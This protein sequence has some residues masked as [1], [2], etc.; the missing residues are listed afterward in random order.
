M[1]RLN[2]GSNAFFSVC[3][4]IILFSFPAAAQRV[5]ENLSGFDHISYSSPQL[6]T[7]ETNR[8]V[9]NLENLLPEQEAASRFIKAKGDGWSVWFDLRRGRPSLIDGGAIP[10]IPGHAN[11]LR[12]EDFAPGCKDNSSLPPEKVEELA[13]GFIR[14]WKDLLK[15]DQEELILDPLG[16]GPVGDSYYL[17]RFQWAPSGIPVEGASVYFRINGGNLLQVATREIGDLKLDITPHLSQETA[18]QILSG[19][20][21]GLAE[22][23][24]ILERGRLVIVPVTPR[25]EDSNLF[26]GRFGGMMDYRLCYKLVFEREG[27]IGRWESLVDAHSGELLSFRDS[28]RYGTVRGTIY[29][30][31]DKENILSLP[32][33]FVKTDIPAPNNF[34]DFAGRFEGDQATLNMENARF[35]KMVDGC[36]NSSLTTTTG[37]ADYGQ[38][39]GEDCGVPSPNPAGGGNTWSIKTLYYHLT[40][41]NRKAAGFLPANSWLSQGQITVNV[42]KS[43]FCN[44]SAGATTINFYKSA[45]GCMNYGELPG[46]GLHEWGHSLDVNDGSGGWTSPCE[47]I[48]DWNAT[49][50][51]RDSCAGKGAGEGGNC[52][53]YGDAC[54]SCDGIRDLDYMKHSSQTP[55]TAQN[56]GTLWD[57]A[58][59]K[60]NGPCGW[61]DHCESGIASQALWDFVNRDLPSYCGISGRD[62]WQLAEMLFYRALPTL[63][64][65]YSCTVGA[66]TVTDGC[67]G[68]SLYTVMRFFDDS[69]DGTANGTPHAK[70]IY[71]AL[72][73]HNIA[74]GAEQDA[75]NQNQSGC[76]SMSTP[77]LTVAS[78]A[79]DQVYLEWTSAGP[80]ATWYGIFRNDLGPDFGFTK[81]G[82]VS[83]PATNFYDNFAANGVW[84]NYVVQAAAGSESCAGP[85]SNIVSANPSYWP[86]LGAVMLDSSKFNCDGQ[87]NITVTDATPGTPVTVQAWST[88]DPNPITIALAPDPTF[89]YRYVGSI[90]TSV[91]A[92]SGKVRV[93]HGDTL[94][95]KYIDP[96]DG[97]GNYNVGIFTHAAIDCQGPQISN[98]RAVNV[99]GT[100]MN[101]V[102]DTDE[103]STTSVQ[104]FPPPSSTSDGGFDT[105]HS[106]S[107]SGLQPCTTY[108]FEMSSAD[109]LGNISTDNNGG[110]Y[111]AFT[112]IPEL[113]PVYVRAPAQTIPDNDFDGV[114]SASSV[115]DGRVVQDLNVSVTIDHPRTSDLRLYVENPNGQ[116]VA[117]VEN[118]PTSGADF[119]GTTFDDD[120]DQTLGGSFG[121]YPG[122]YRPTGDL[123]DYDG[124]QMNGNWKLVV[125]DTVPGETGT[126]VEWELLPTYATYNCGAELDLHD[127]YIFS[128]HCTGS[129]GGEDG[130]I[131]AG[132]EVTLKAYLYNNGS[133]ETSQV[134][135]FLTS[136]SPFVTIVDGSSSFSDILPGGTGG[137]ADSFKILVSPDTQCGQPLELNL[138]I[139]CYEEP[140]GWD[141][142]VALI[143]GDPDP[144]G[145][146]VNA[147]QEDFE[148]IVTG[149]P[150]GWKKT[151]AS[152]SWLVGRETCCG[153]SDYSLSILTGGKQADAWMFTS[154]MELTPGTLYTLQFSCN[155]DNIDSG[156][157]Q[158][159][160]LYLGSGQDASLMNMLL[161]RETDLVISTGCITYTVEFTVPEQAEYYLGIYC[162]TPPGSWLLVIDDI[163]ISYQSVASC[164]MNPC[165]PCEDPGAPVITSITDPYPCEAGSLRVWF[166]EGSGAT[167]HDLYMDGTLVMYGIPSSPA[168]IAPGDDDPH[169]FVIRAINGECHTDSA[170]VTG[171]D[172]DGPA[173]G[174]P[175]P[176]AADADE[177][178]PTGIEVSWPAV[179]GATS[180]DLK[181][182]GTTIVDDAA[183][184]YIYSPGNSSS[185]AFSVRAKNG[186]CAGSWSSTVSS[187]DLVLKPGTPAVPAV[188][189][190]DYCA[191]TGV[192]VSWI[193]VP[194]ATD[195]DLMIDGT[196]VINSV[197]SPHVYLPGNTNTHNY[198]VRAIRSS[199]KGDFSPASAGID[200]ITL[201][202]PAP[203]SV[204]DIDPCAQSG[205]SV[206]WSPVPGATTYDL[207]VDGSD[208]Y[209]S[210]TSPYAFDPKDTAVH[211]YSI[212]P[213]SPSCDGD[214][215]DNTEQADLNNGVS[216]PSSFGG[217]DDD[218]CN[219][220]G[221]RL[222]WSAASGATGYDLMVDSNTITGVSSPYVHVP[223][224]TDTHA[225]RVRAKN[226]SCV[227]DWTASL[228][229]KDSA[230]GPPV[231]D[232]APGASDL[233]A[234][235]LTGIRVY[236]DPLP[237]ATYHDIRVDGTTI[238]PDA[239]TEKIIEPGDSLP[240][241]FEYRGRTAVCTG[242]WSPS[243][244][245][246]DING[247]PGAPVVTSVDDINPSFP[248]GVRVNF[249][250]GSGAERHDLYMDGAQ[251]VTFYVSGDPFVPGDALLH[252][253][254]VRAVNGDCY[255]VSNVEQGTDQP[256][257]KPG[258]IAPGL[259]PETAQ[260]W[261]GTT[262]QTWPADSSCSSGYLLYRGTMADLPLL[263]DS[264][265]DSCVVFRGYSAGENTASGLAEDPS[266]VPGKF[267]W[268]IV[269]G[270]N[271]SGE[272]TAGN[273]SG[274]E[275]VVDSGGDCL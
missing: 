187:A 264:S 111:F 236:F 204:T 59:G 74:C 245:G 62:A 106:I 45:S 235:A 180:Y 228:E 3:L 191:L 64:N 71:K 234:C 94:T 192:Q 82:T 29:G 233:N 28:D 222:T 138:H 49:L 256:P 274:G 244:S 165:E 205:V 34:A 139:A 210:V 78:A 172:E 10:F 268:Y 189:D 173:P 21:G 24:R 93:S 193:A 79:N 142:P 52:S 72:A 175:S 215:S 254:Q 115:F 248:N 195:Y 213:K 246:T 214:R 140:A 86:A 69:G 261:I 25:G 73:R 9:Q 100:S 230:D 118:Y 237:G 50:Q 109:E 90:Q 255:S 161:W 260:S 15:V 40:W 38:S 146:I 30:N 163:S 266:I 55:W 127:I 31:D 17:I 247:T 229:E 231:P 227:S 221:I 203:P 33:P 91:T 36:G 135:G 46:A 271:A 87:V 257:Q 108:H 67:G 168:F 179:P 201:E 53:S 241:T 208:V 249:T 116:R 47:T 169:E 92:G 99:T 101:I 19:Y 177:C 65:L 202:T 143:V 267:Y 16:S 133:V 61:E 80:N 240:H 48:A 81:I 223:G 77:V 66:P 259:T 125:M 183:N 32:L 56:H 70:A 190:L 75:A 60:Y 20:T 14:E 6:R 134:S 198:Q 51:L 113:T 119:D 176:S 158:S 85:M 104:Y 83:A 120:T 132:E 162:D 23:D 145:N 200:R 185:H 58:S 141:I 5:K 239:G 129:G 150:D 1:K 88:T 42:N 238:L 96:D 178:D 153:T 181:I 207:V 137:D 37:Y 44:A 253:F 63:G 43:P 12:W 209:T 105:F 84:S 242:L 13:R 252:D 197:T 122:K 269:T 149:I 11:S 2:L 217:G 151:T 258:E 7:V 199:C 224:D 216:V 232:K 8:Q 130:I 159:L 265:E 206:S 97:N 41:A 156:I 225:F 110:A 196:T 54:T 4:S 212:M 124:Q 154:G 188:S 226:A 35:L 251:V 18:W 103:L 27:T 95:V 272:G 166:T 114:W 22:N 219:P 220:T 273:G 182:D 57:C 171:S 131:D 275:R 263:L 152:P 112:T 250:A 117:L 76:A 270:L 39:V 211:G 147:L 157:G 194:D 89:M 144:G 126:V 123:S 136:S 170:P 184:P 98:V 68:D 243:A 121:P 262:T 128:E 102:W 164:S 167:Q 160:S 26:N 218:P 174:I 148:D 155:A 107:V 186:N